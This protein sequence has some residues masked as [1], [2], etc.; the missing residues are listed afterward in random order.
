MSTVKVIKIED[1]QLKTFLSERLNDAYEYRRKFEAEWKENEITLLN[2]NGFLDEVAIPT[3]P[4]E[5]ATYLTTVK[6]TGTIGVNYVFK[7]WR[8]IHAQLSANPPTVLARP[9]SADH[10]DRQRAD[11]ADRLNR[12]AMRTYKV[13]ERCD[14][15]SAHTLTYGTGWAYTG[16]NKLGGDVKKFNR[17]TMEVTMKGDFE[18]RTPSVWDVWIDPRAKCWDDVRYVWERIRYPVDE[19]KMLFPHKKEAIDKYV[20]KARNVTRYSDRYRQN[21]QE[22]SVEIYYYWEKGLPQ[23]GMIGRYCACFRD[24]VPLM[25]MAA[26]PA[27]VVPDLTKEDREDRDRL[28]RSDE[29]PWEEP[30]STAV[31][32]FHIFTDIDVPD[33][34]YGKSFI[35]Y[36]AE[37]QDIL[38]RLDS[39]ELENIQ[40]FGAVKLVLP[41]SA[42]I[43]D[44]SLSDSP[45]D[46]IKITGNQSPHFMNAPS[47][48]PEVS[49]FRDRM[50]SGGDDMA[51]I[52]E[53]MFGQQSREQS[54]FSMQYATN[55]GN[56]IR[57]RLFNKYVL[58]VESIYKSYLSIV[59]KHWKVP[60]MVKVLGQERAF[61]AVPLKGADIDGG[62]DLVVEYGASLSLDPTTRREEILQL[63]PLFEKAGV[64][65][66]TMM[67][68]L[69]L[70]ELEGIYDIVDL[71]K[72]RQYELFDEMINTGE[73][74]PP[75]ELQDHQGMLK[76]AYVYVMEAKFKYLPK[77]IQVLIETHIKDRELLAAKG[78]GADLGTNM[79]G[80]SPGPAGMA[81]ASPE[82]GLDAVLGG[83][84]EAGVAPIQGIIPEG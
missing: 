80:G 42:N 49:S 60:R 68:M 5:L 58:F 54:G 20:S 59:R 52:N 61:E 78:V 83:A 79:E 71:P 28:R 48:M 41:E 9:T 72:L 76:W 62:F 16:W 50:K 17:E 37:V 26:N 66:K 11:A 30:E 45:V 84:A 19:A 55:Q 7:N 12:H 22:K 65:M 24:G 53:S 23:N 57:R 75:E 25:S 39:L 10:E 8:Y 34:V 67:G 6:S 64:D 47:Q 46:V 1:H 40:T 38:N 44:D 81:G 14:G 4:S 27:T 51:G 21:L 32:P 69:R 36:A 35:E 33:Q 43:A 29:E 82:P 2:A 15:S 70:N 31:L 74:I 56:M 13:P 18:L 3:D 73:Y 77:D 63:M